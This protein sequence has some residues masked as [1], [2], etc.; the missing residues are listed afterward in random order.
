MKKMFAFILCICLAFSMLSTAYASTVP[1]MTGVDNVTGIVMSADEFS[2]TY[3]SK[4]N[5]RSAK[6]AIAS[7][8]TS[9]ITLSNLT[10]NSNDLSTTVVLSTNTGTVK[11]PIVGKLYASYKWNQG[12][13]SVIVDVESVI[14]GYNVLLFE[15]YNDF[16]EDS[17]LLYASQLANTPHIKLY[18][19]DENETLYLYEMEMPSSLFS[20][21]ASNFLKAD[22]AKDLFWPLHL[23]NGIT[24]EIPTNDSTLQLFGIDS[25]SRAVNETT[26]W[27]NSTIYQHSFTYMGELYKS[28]SLPYVEYRYTDVTSADSTWWASF[29]IMGYTTIGDTT[30][31]DSNVFEYKNIKL[32]FACGDNSTFIRTYQQGRMRN[33][34]GLIKEAGSNITVDLLTKIVNAL[35]Y[36]S[37]FTT[38]MGYINTLSATEDSVKLGTSGITL[39]NRKTVAVGQKLDSYS[40]EECTDYDSQLNNGHYFTYH[41]VITYENSGGNTNTVGALQAQFDVF[42]AS[43][44]SQNTVTKNIQ[45]NYTAEP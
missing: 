26:C 32:A 35:P 9:S 23:V 14:N 38:V 16:A 41:A 4:P 29:K 22:S 34:L 33:S 15:L 19:Q 36:G 42:D 8:P 7:C 31:Y 3:T 40:F 13:N 17:K 5:G 43:D 39:M 21:D 28:Y 10:V 2:T 11:L 24:T 6:A 18:I 20:I 12:I 30:L 44:Y 27:Y 1:A 25:Q 37:T 45:L